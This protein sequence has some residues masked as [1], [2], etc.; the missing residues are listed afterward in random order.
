VPSARNSNYKSTCLVSFLVIIPT[1]QLQKSCFALQPSSV[2]L[3]KVPHTTH[4]HPSIASPN[5]IRSCPYPR[6]LR[7]KYSLDMATSTSGLTFLTL[8]PERAVEKHASANTAGTS[9]VVTT[10]VV[11]PQPAVQKTRRSSSTSTTTSTQNASEAGVAP[12]TS[13]FLRLGV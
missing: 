9:A 2:F 7:D 3:K 8:L 10:E 5:S 1:K 11:H 4:S 12:F 6:Y 13:G